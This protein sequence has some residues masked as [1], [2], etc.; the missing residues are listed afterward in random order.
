MCGIAGIYYFDRDRPVD[1]E[2]LILLRDTATHRGPDECGIWTR[3]GI[4]LAHRRLSIIDLEGGKQP[5]ENLNTGNAITYNGEIYNFRT[6]QSSFKNLVTNSDTETLLRLFEN[7]A[8]NAIQE[9]NG[10]FAFAFYRQSDKTLTLVRDRLGQKPLFYYQT[11]QRLVFASEL[12]Q[13]KQLPD[14]PAEIRMQ[15][16]HDYLSLHYIPCPFTAYKKVYKLLP[17]TFLKVMPNGLSKTKQYWSLNF[18]TNHSLSFNDASEALRELLT[19]AVSKRMISDVP[20]GAFLSGGMDSTIITGIMSKLSDQ[21]VKTFTI[22][23]PD[24]R[25]NET[26][27]AQ[28]AANAFHTDHHCKTVNPQDFSVIEKLTANLG[29][30]Y[31]DA[32]ILPTHLLS[33]FTGEHVKTALS[34][35]AA[36][37]LFGGYYRYAVI[38]TLRKLDR[39]P[40]S[41][42]KT[43][44][45]AALKLLP[46]ATEERTTLGKLTRLLNLA[47]ASEQSRLL[48]IGNRFPESLKANICGTS[49]RSSRHTTNDF[50]SR[51]AS[52]A[53][54]DDPNALLSEIDIHTYLLNDILTKVDIASMSSS[55]EVRSPFLDH[56]IVEFAATLPWKWKQ[57]GKSRKLILQQTF[58][59]LIPTELQTRPKLGFGVPLAQWF[60]NEWKDIL[61]DILL[62]TSALQSGFYNPA[63]LKNMIE[64]HVSGRADFS[65]PL[66]SL[67]I[68][69]LWRKK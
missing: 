46:N 5:M 34:G 47:G 50:I 61:N 66:W 35:D 55:L 60:R 1:K 6:L 69:E 3:P 14:F 59:N 31:S 24:P 45:A 52:N 11:D 4:G 51:C 33:S 23:F 30:P 41:L 63:H 67:L 49:F 54:C 48:D 10:M 16:L 25:Y 56:R 18:H 9:L 28:T 27:F 7:K 39:I 17:G 42:R 2:E 37:E 19:D 21:P 57:K 68:L 43:L 15:S 29:E 40:A 44:S 62:S 13:L 8:E 36:D 32:S 64:N 22:G 26:E 58:E 20:L 38:N 53:T 65:Y 12:N